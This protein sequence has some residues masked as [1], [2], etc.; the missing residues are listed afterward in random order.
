MRNRSDWKRCLLSIM[1][2]ANIY[3]AAAD[4][5]AA[6]VGPALK[7]RPNSRARRLTRIVRDEGAE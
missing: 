6:Q 3:V 2:L 4:S 7:P 1:L 5:S